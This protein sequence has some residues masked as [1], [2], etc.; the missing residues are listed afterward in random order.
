MDTGHTTL[1]F[2]SH[3]LASSHSTQGFVFGSQSERP[4]GVELA[5]VTD[6]VSAAHGKALAL[7]AIEIAAPAQK[8]WGQVVS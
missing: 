7:G 2:A 4:L 8:P 1:S 6:D 3:E 5:F